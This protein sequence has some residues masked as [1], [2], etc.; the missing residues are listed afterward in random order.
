MEFSHEFFVD[1]NVFLYFCTQLNKV[2]KTKDNNI[3][4]IYIIKHCAEQ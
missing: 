2:S 4:E 1:N 3:Y